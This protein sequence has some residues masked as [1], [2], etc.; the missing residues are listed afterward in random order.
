[1]LGK[2]QIALENAF[3]NKSCSHNSCLR[4]LFPE[5]N[6]EPKYF[7]KLVFMA[8]SWSSFVSGVHNKTSRFFWPWKLLIFYPSVQVLQ[9]EHSLILSTPS[10]S[11]HPS[12]PTLSPLG[13]LSW[14][15]SSCCFSPELLRPSLREPPS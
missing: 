5:L 11:S 1:M 2:I 7:S 3:S 8:A 10:Y 12:P 6:W 15:H 13:L 14:R 4:E 9:P